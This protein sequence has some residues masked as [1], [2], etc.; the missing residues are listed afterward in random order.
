MCYLSTRSKTNSYPKIQ[1]RKEI[2]NM[3]NI[4]ELMFVISIFLCVAGFIIGMTDSISNP[5]SPSVCYGGIIFI[6]GVAYTIAFLTF[7]DTIKE[8]LNS[9]VANQP[10][11]WEQ[12]KG[13]YIAHYRGW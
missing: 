3:E 1:K 12:V 8:W 9:L 5:N 2:R 7:P 10:P 13:W 6:V 11:T 4:G